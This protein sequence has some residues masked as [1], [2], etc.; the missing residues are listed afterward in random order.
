MSK[1]TWSRRHSATPGNTVIHGATH[2][3][4]AGDTEKWGA[5]EGDAGLGCEGWSEISYAG[6]GIPGTSKNQGPE[7]R[8]KLECAETLPES[9]RSG[10]L[11]H[12]EIKQAFQGYC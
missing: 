3:E 10:S 2:S 5:E 4:R 7:E 8:K 12:R 6:E 9:G 11:G 1:S